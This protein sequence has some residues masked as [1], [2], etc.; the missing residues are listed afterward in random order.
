M[1]NRF[2][3]N[4]G[5]SDDAD[6]DE[7]LNELQ[8][9]FSVDLEQK[10]EVFNTNPHVEG[11][12]SESDEEVSICRENNSSIYA[13]CSGL[14]SRD[15]T[16]VD[17]RID[18]LY[19][20]VK[21][22]SQQMN[23]LQTQIQSLVNLVQNLSPEPKCQCNCGNQNSSK[24]PSFE[25][26]GNPIFTENRRL[27]SDVSEVLPRCNF[28]PTLMPGMT[29]NEHNFFSTVMGTLRGILSESDLEID[30]QT[31]PEVSNSVYEG[32]NDDK[33]MLNATIEQLRRLGV[34]FI[35]SRQVK[36]VLLNISADFE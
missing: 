17:D 8:R 9:R 2:Y 24:P 6:R 3:P 27:P 7:W 32:T 29:Q 21:L 10:S 20:I 1:E 4:S 31:N 5:P 34:S 16:S 33:T 30:H 23:L 13:P 26:P 22:H 14:K 12:S 18:D 25:R 36:M 11:C 35:E 15:R 28:D 19:R